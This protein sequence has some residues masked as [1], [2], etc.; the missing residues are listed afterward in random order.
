MRVLKIADVSR[1][2]PG[3]IRSF[4]L[5]TGDALTEMGHD[6]D[7]LFREDLHP[8]LFPGT[9]ARRLAIPWLVA[10][11]LVRRRGRRYDVIDIH[12]AAAS[13]Y[14]RL[15]Q[16]LR[17]LP[18]CVLSSWGAEERY[19]R[20]YDVRARRVGL[21]QRR[22]K[23]L[24]KRLLIRDS[25]I[26]FMNADH[27]LVP[28]EDDLR[29][30][31]EELGVP[32]ERMTRVDSGVDDSYFSVARQPDSGATRIAFIGSWC[33]KK[34]SPELVH[35]WKRLVAENP[36]VRLSALCTVAPEA[37]V[38]ADFGDASDGVVVQPFVTD[39]ALRNAL[40]VHD[41]FVLPSWF[42]GG[43]A[44]AA[45]Q[46][47][48]AGLACVVTDVSGHADLFRR[49]DPEADGALIVPPHDAEALT[50]ALVRLTREPDL[51]ARL[52][53][54]AR[55]RARAFSW[56]ETAR[57]SLEGYEQAVKSAAHAH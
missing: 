8:G 57:R 25:R 43:M 30:L 26:A 5:R 13:T 20:E 14:T 15:R 29:Y 49:D 9:H 23:A 56:R 42:E 21:K 33:D 47:A 37:S 31:R 53:E 4:M 3:G 44:L 17:A 10:W 2:V 6:V 41:V 55:R 34:G 35:A 39:D 51:V 45:Q 52:G 32:L 28:S 12:D 22:G 24:W 54:N 27:I 50:Q 46:A 36:R 38:L 1:G 16:I 19:W 48:S 7:Y 11:E 18:P 40:S